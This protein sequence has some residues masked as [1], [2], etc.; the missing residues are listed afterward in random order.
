LFINVSI[1]THLK[2]NNAEFLLSKGNV[3][4]KSRAG[5]WRFLQELKQE[6]GQ[7]PWKSLAYSQWLTQ[8][9][10]LYHQVLSA[11]RWHHPMVGKII[12]LFIYLFIHSFIHSF[13]YSSI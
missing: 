12:H 2:N 9:G 7:E 13:I 1:P 10:F 6:Q 5:G 8:P 4:T 3:E 11:Q